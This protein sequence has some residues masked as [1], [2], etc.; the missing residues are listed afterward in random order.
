M[1]R[2]WRNLAF[3]VR[4]C[5]VLACGVLASAL[6][7]GCARRTLTITSE[8]SGATVVVN[9]VELGR[10][11]LS[12]EFRFYGTYDVL[13]TKEGFEPLR[14]RAKAAAPIYE[15]PPLDVGAAVVGSHTRRAWH[16]TLSPALEASEPRE[17][18]EAGILRRARELEDRL[19]GGRQTTEGR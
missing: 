19:K 18:F 6:A 4:A 16:F 1:R 13:V 14:T 9:E 17:E 5:A 12:A 2:A 7:G 8:P 11:P 10:T 3:G 15:Y